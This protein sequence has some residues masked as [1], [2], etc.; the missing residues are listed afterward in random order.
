MKT[1][2][3]FVW[4]LLIFSV[5]FIISA[6]LSFLPAEKICGGTQT[7]CYEVQT[8]EYEE[9]FGIKSSVLGLICFSIIL[10]FI[11]SEI[12]TPKKYKRRLIF[13]GIILFSIFAIYFI[14]LQLFVIKEFCQYCLVVDIGVL[15]SLF[16]I[17]R[18]N[19]Y[20]SN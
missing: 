19:E 3:R 8:S 11:I 7:G 2:K 13:L 6:I 14:Y 15:I 12:K 18:K 9:I 20:K 16:I 17:W 10:S 1:K 5:L 4:L